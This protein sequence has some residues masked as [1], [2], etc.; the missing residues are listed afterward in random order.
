MFAALAKLFNFRQTEDD[1]FDNSPS[2]FSKLV[3]LENTKRHSYRRN[4][5]DEISRQQFPVGW[6]FFS[7]RNTNTMTKH[8]KAD[9]AFLCPIMIRVY[10]SIGRPMDADVTADERKRLTEAVQQLN[11]ETI[12]QASN[13]IADNA[14]SHRMAVNIFHGRDMRP[15]SNPSVVTT[16]RV[17]NRKTHTLNTSDPAADPAG[18]FGR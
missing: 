10:D 17:E 6:R 8:L 11:K 4:G 3:Q 5:D 14:K 16:S 15:I 7:H 18:M 12:R 13:I 1:D 2:H 9:F